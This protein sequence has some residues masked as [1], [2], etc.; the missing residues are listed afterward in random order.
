MRTDRALTIASSER[1]FAYSLSP[2]TPMGLWGCT[3]YVGNRA[4]EE[5]CSG[6]DRSGRFTSS[7]NGGRKS[8]HWLASRGS[9]HRT[10]L[11]PLDPG[12]KAVLVRLVRHVCF[13]GS[14]HQSGCVPR[15]ACFRML[16][17]VK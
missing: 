9:A 6:C 7:V 4:E 10:G 1:V 2:L 3:N 15:Q 8:T 12:Q 13:T 14:E 16:A 17:S 5:R 11:R